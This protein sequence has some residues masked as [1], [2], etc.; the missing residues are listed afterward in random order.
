MSTL[1]AVIT[2]AFLGVLLETIIRQLS[3]PNSQA[4]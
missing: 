3:Y 4:K 1:F 2:Y